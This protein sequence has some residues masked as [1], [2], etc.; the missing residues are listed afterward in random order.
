MTYTEIKERNG[1]KYYY[2]VIS[3]R[4]DDKV[5]KQ[6]K[7]LGVNLP[8]KELNKFELDADKI[9]N[10]KNKRE[11][12]EIRAIKRKIINVFKKYKIVRAGIFGSYARGDYKKNSDIDILVDI[13]DKKMSLLGFVHI[14]H[15]LEDLLKKKVD[16]VQYKMIRSEIKDNIL[17]D[18][19]RIYEKKWIFISKRYF[20]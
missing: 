13:R 3:I 6:R 7:Y 8:K 2:R 5:T 11:T 1:R 14:K 10:I 12:R 20:R 4:R 15:E 9:L 19:V 16:L 17:K 18:E